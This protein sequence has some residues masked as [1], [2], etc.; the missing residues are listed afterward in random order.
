MSEGLRLY[1]VDKFSDDA[2]VQ[3][4]RQTSHFHIDPYGNLFTGH[5]PGISVTN[6]DNLHPAVDES[7]APFFTALCE[8]GPVEA[9]KRYASEFQPDTTGYIGKCHFCL[10]LR[11]HLFERN[12]FAEL[13]PAEMYRS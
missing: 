2:C 4:F 5:C 11:S 13:R 9:W 7:A 1:P 6:V 10:E 12:T 3:T 8:G